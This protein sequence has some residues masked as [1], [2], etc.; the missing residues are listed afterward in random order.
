MTR[1]HARPLLLQHNILYCASQQREEP[2]EHDQ[3]FGHPGHH[4]TPLLAGLSPGGRAA[5]LAA[6]DPSRADRHTEERNPSMMSTSV[7]ALALSAG[8]ILPGSALAES[9]K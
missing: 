4:W 8:V 1:S 7:V 5:R 2:G 3:S 9:P 6:P